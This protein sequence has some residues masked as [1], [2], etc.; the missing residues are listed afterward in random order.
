MLSRRQL[1]AIFAKLKGKGILK[2]MAGPPADKPSSATRGLDAIFSKERPEQLLARLPQ[3]H[4]N[5]GAISEVEIWD[6]PV[7]NKPGWV[8]AYDT[9]KRNIHVSRSPVE[10]GASIGYDKKL[11]LHSP[12]GSLISRYKY[13]RNAKLGAAKSFYHEY[14]HS[15]WTV[16]VSGKKRSFPAMGEWDGVERDEAFADAYSF[17]ATNKIS[18]NKLR[19]NKPLTY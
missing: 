12:R 8:G 4:R 1:A 2:R 14:G 6:T 11:P 15:L 5:M 10:Y 16:V 7:F 13:A 9:W 17:Y 18:R 3:S 19:K